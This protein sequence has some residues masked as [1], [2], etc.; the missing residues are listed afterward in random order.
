MTIKAD[1]LDMISSTKSFADKCDPLA[2]K[3]LV[4]HIITIDNSFEDNKINEEDRRELRTSVKN[5]SDKFGRSCYC[6]ETYSRL[7]EKLEED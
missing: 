7:I 6:N 2:V 4:T 1:I 3:R 5:I